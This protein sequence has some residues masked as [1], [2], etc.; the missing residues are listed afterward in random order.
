MS[1]KASK[2]IVLGGLS[3]IGEATARAFAPDGATL[4]V[5][6][7]NGDRLSQVAQDLEARG[8]KRAIVWPIDLAAVEDKGQE[9][10][11]MVTSLG[12]RVDAVLLVYGVLGD[13]REAESNTEELRNLIAVNYVSAAEW[14]MASAVVLE[15]QKKGV[16]LVIGSVAGDRG[17][18]SNYVYG[19]AKAALGVFVEGL[20]HRLAPTGARAVV[21]RLGFVDTP[22]TA[23]LEKGGALWTTPSNVA[24]ALKRIV[25]RPSAP[26]VYV[27]WFW[28]PIMAIIR[29]VPTSIFHRTKL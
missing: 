9:L 21:V 29:N 7:R 19:S 16:L 14:C 15:R 20:A 18:Q 2:I 13:Q 6:G 17:R 26:V 28:R 24:R 11:K 25:E 4:L 10:E 27:P 22:M 5:A 3:A 23:H 8:A 1:A 12:G